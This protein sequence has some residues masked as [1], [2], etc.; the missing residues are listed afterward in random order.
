MD[1]ILQKALMPENIQKGSNREPFIFDNDFYGQT[2]YWFR[3]SLP[4][5]IVT[6]VYLVL[7]FPLKVAVS[8]LGLLSP[9]N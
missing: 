9:L 8:I 6:I 2:N 1:R 7:Y 4:L 3:T 5:K